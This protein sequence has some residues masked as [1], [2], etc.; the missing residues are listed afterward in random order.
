MQDA[1]DGRYNPNARV[2]PP[3]WRVEVDLHLHTTVSDGTLSPSKLIEF[4]S[5][6]S[7]KTIAVTDHDTTAGVYE[8]T[9]AASDGLTVIPGIELGTATDDSELHLLGYFIDI[10]N[11]ELQSTLETFREQRVDAARAMVAKLGEMGLPVSWNR[12]VELA[13][14][15]VGRPHIARA[16]VE[17]GHVQTV[18]EAFDRFIGEK[19]IA[20]VP[21]PK[22]HPTDALRLIH[23]AGGVGVVAHPRTVHRL[24]P[25]VKQLAGNG[26]AGIEVYAEKY[27]GESRDKYLDIATRYSLVPSGGTDY[28]AQDTE[29]EVLPGQNGP[30]PNTA[31]R[32]LE[33]AAE[34]HGSRVGSVP[35]GL[36]R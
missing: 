23:G 8:A 1:A 12:V 27:R 34:M 19:G 18:R 29:N 3:E 9:N 2:E 28:H 33:K 25:L 17:E 20:R 15:A 6:T 21:R 13:A 35:E 24:N 7:L 14:G 32:L 22:L 26:L 5:G 31:H 30:E 10:E 16:M 4:I 11:D 36:R